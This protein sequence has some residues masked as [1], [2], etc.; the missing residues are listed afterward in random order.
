M[1]FLYFFRYLLR[2]LGISIIIGVVLSLIAGSRQSLPMSNRGHRFLLA[3]LISLAIFILLLLLFPVLVFLT[4]RRKQ[5]H[6]L[7]M[8]EL[9]QKQM[10]LLADVTRYASEK[11]YWIVGIAC[12]VMIILAIADAL[13]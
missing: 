10:Q 13:I 4:T 8:Q 9:D 2:A 1:L 7:T 3:G 6:R 12:G 11:W 5:Q